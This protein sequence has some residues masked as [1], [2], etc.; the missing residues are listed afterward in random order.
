MAS[1]HPDKHAAILDAAQ[2][3]FA[4]Y[5]LTKVTMD[6]IAADLGISKAALYYYFPNKEDIYRNVVGCEQQDFA[7]RMETIVRGN[8]PAAGKLSG[9]F[10][11]HLRLIGSLLDLRIVEVRAAYPVKPIMRDLFQEFSSTETRFLKA[12]MREGKKRREFAVDFPEKTAR[13]VQHVLQGLRMRFITIM[14]GREPGAADIRAYRDEVLY[15]LK[16]FLKG[17]SR[18][19]NGVKN[20]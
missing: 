1:R 14:R 18:Q 17:I 15:F 6:E 10:A 12:I 3:R 13:L 2:K 5:G 20:T 4:R 9:Y 16:I 8:A 7:D 19:Q 11:E